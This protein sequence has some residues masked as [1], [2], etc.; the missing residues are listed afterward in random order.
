MDTENFWADVEVDETE[1]GTFVAVLV[2]GF[3]EDPDQV[4]RVPLAGEHA[5]PELA[6]SAAIDAIASMA[7]EGEADGAD[8]VA[9]SA[10][11]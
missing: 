6:T 2:M 4:T 8:A 1:R 5:L 11:A 3:G 7:L 10:E 9:P